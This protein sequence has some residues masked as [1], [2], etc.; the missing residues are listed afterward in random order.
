MIRGPRPLS[1]QWPHVSKEKGQ[2]KG[3]KISPV[4]ST[5]Q[6][7][8]E[9]SKVARL[10]AALKAL[11]Q[12]QSPAKIALEEALTMATAKVCRSISSCGTIG[13]CSKSVGGGR[14]RCLVESSPQTARIHTRVRPVGE[15]LDLCLQYISRVKKQVA[16]AEEQVRND[17][18]VQRQMEEK[19]ANGLR[20]LEVLRGGRLNSH[21]RT[22]TRV[23]WNPWRKSPD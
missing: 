18:E 4:V 16:R 15:R 14:P 13:S 19:L 12:E 23:R 21:G 8:Q 22:K 9:Q 7:S 11:G 1:V 17:I 6:K 10:E 20:D 2:G 3:K 5:P